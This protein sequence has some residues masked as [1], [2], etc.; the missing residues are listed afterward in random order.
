MIKNGG[1]IGPQN[2]PSQTSGTGYAPVSLSGVF[3]SFQSYNHVKQATWPQTIRANWTSVSSY[4]PSEGVAFTT[5]INLSGA[6]SGLTLHYSIIG[7]SGDINAADFYDGLLQGTFIT[8]SEWGTTSSGEF[9]K[10]LVTSDGT[11]TESFTIQI[12]LTNSSGPL[13]ATTSTITPVNAEALYP[14]TSF[15]FTAAS[16]AG[17][18]GPTLANCL[19]SYSTATYPWLNNTT[20]FNV[21]TQGIQQWQVPA[22]GTY[23]LT[24]KGATGGIHGGSYYPGFPGAGATAQADIALSMGTIVYIVVG[25]KPTSITSSSGNGSGGGGGTFVYT[26]ASASGGIGGAGLL[27]VAGGGGGTG[28]GSSSTT[29]GNG[30]GG[31]ATTNSAEGVSGVSY[32]INARA[33]TGSAGNKGIGQGGNQT[34]VNGNGTGGGAGWLSDGTSFGVANGGLRFQGGQSEDGSTMYGGWG[35]GAG[36]GGNGNAGGGAGG[37]TGGGAGQGFNN[38]SWGGGA[39]GGSYAAAGATNVVMTAG[40]S[41]INYVDVA[42]GYVT[43]ALL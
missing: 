12:R 14:F 18:Q 1:I 41:G 28:H 36:S 4:T 9:S 11:E 27:L 35:G 8:Y 29:A 25:Q 10:T 43:I 23:R 38:T 5:K 33:G 21:V 24:A 3:D 22:T 30:V 31:S 6:I 15:T 40:S 13:L 42:S 39:G 19:A 20:Y 16:I 37:Y 2:I 17:Y 26:G 32:G 7:I 34:T